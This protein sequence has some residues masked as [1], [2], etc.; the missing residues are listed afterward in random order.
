VEF[1]RELARLL[2]RNGRE[3]DAFDRY[4]ELLALRPDTSVRAEYAAALLA[5]AQYDSA[6]GEYRVLVASDSLD[7]GYHLG[8]A[9]SL[10][11]GN[12]PRES[13]PELHWLVVRSPNDTTLG[14]MLRVARNAYD[15]SAAEASRWVTE[16]SSY[17]PY[18]LAL[19]RAAS[20]ERLWPLAFAEFDTLI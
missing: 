16:D 3:Q 13:E 12:H 17:V 20:R 9:R 11:W 4:R 19:A 18:R 10:A 8:L 5:R 7:R 1:G 6:A 15:P 2:A 14:T